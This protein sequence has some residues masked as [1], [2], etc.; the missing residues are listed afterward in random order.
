M[1][2][3]GGCSHKGVCWEGEV[4]GVRGWV[5]SVWGHCKRER[6]CPAREN[7]LQGSSQPLGGHLRCMF[8]CKCCAWSGLRL[9][10]QKFTKYTYLFP[11]C[12]KELKATLLR[13]GT[14]LCPQHAEVSLN[15]RISDG[16]ILWYASVLPLRILVGRDELG[17]VS[18]KVRGI[19]AVV[20]ASPGSGVCVSPGRVIAS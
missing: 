19:R 10:S 2:G 16:T 11:S 1:W 8:I 17:T 15:S 6:S 5:S 4:T 13:R 7:S 14:V 12:P 20:P 9:G 3:V 18:W